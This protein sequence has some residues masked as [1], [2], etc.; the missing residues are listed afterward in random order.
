MVLPSHLTRES[1]RDINNARGVFGFL[2]NFFNKALFYG[3]FYFICIVI[4]A[5]LFISTASAFAIWDTYEIIGPAEL[6]WNSLAISDD[7]KYISGVVTG[8]TVTVSKPIYVSTDYG[9]TFTAKNSRHLWNGIAMSGNGQYQTAVGGGTTAY[10][11]YIYRSTDYGATWTQASSVNSRWQN[12]G[13]SKDGRYQTAIS[14]NAGIAPFGIALRSSDFGATWSEVT[15]LYKRSFGGIAVSETG[16]YQIISDSLK[17][18][19]YSSDYG[20]TW[21][22]ILTTPNGYINSVAMSADG[23]YMTAVEYQGY[24]WISSDRG[25]S[26][27]QIAGDKQRWRSVKMSSDGKYQTAVAT[28]NK[29][30]TPPWPYYMAVSED[31]GQ[32]WTSKMPLDVQWTASAM[33]ADGAKQ[34]IAS[35]VSGNLSRIYKSFAVV[36]DTTAPAAVSDLAAS[37]PSDSAVT[38]TWTAPGDDGSSGTATSYDIR[39]STSNITD[40]NWASATPVSGEPTPLVAGTSQSKTV[41]GLSASTTYYFALK[42][43]DEVPNWSSISNVPSLATTATPDTTAPAAVSDLAASSPSNSAITLT[44]TSPGDDAN[45]GTATTY[46]LRYSASEITAGNFDSATPVSDEPTP[47]V[48]GTSQSKTVTGLS[49][50]TTYYFALKTADEVPNWSSISN[51]PSLATLTLAE[52]EKEGGRVKTTTIIFS[53]KAFPGAK[54]LVLVKDITKNITSEEPVSQE[55]SITNEEGEFSVGFLYRDRMPGFSFGSRNSFGL[56]IKDKDNRAT[57]TKFF[58]TDIF[59]DDLIVKDLLVPPTVG[60]LQRVISRGQPVIIIGYA[61]PNNSIILE[62]DNIIKKEAKVEKDGSYKVAVDTGIL[63]FG[64]YHVRVK[65]V[66]TSQKRESDYS[67]TNAFVVSHLTLPKTDLNGDGVVNIK[68]WSMFLSNWGSKDESRKKIIDLNDDGKVDIA[69]F[70]IFIR[71]IKK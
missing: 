55:D 19:E 18:V 44:W 68:D 23:M 57:Q 28:G 27:S 11:N 36:S 32:T 47:L 39:Y 12:V 52:S 13:M 71:T 54:I 62:I 6:Q 43:A 49:A 65:Q 33:S 59:A 61:S 31:Y 15:A 60:F 20:A 69:D 45:S 2:N 9:V 10:P 53:G 17:N 38:L 7:G 46:D 5:I 4:A 56:L 70:S 58:N 34:V 14:T 25:L 16:Q 48:A 21:T 1:K 22:K 67:P 51:V 40:G 3:A 24:V 8:G 42:T 64:T 63:E 41:T 35:F 26:W 30:T 50:S 37:S 29:I 66:D